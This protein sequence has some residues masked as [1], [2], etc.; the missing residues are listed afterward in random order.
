MLKSALLGAAFA[1][2]PLALT[3]QTTLTAETTTPGSTPHYIDSTLAAVLDSAGVATMQITEGATLT[4]S[5]QAVAEGQL[6]MAPAPLILPF[7][8][9]RGIGPY[10]G[11]GPERGA[12]L[13][14]NLRVIFFN[15]GSAQ[16]F[17]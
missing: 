7:L 17:G 12:E 11:I 2:A 14:S 3:A 6:D 9:S 1:I 13:A 16:V 5:V 4:N 10:S 8:L 15:A